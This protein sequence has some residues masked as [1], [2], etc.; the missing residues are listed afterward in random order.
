MPSLVQ[1]LVITMS[2]K[3][4]CEASELAERPQRWSALLKE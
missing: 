4:S 3:K 2:R 1:Y